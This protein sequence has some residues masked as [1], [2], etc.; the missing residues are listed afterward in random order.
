MGPRPC[1]VKVESHQGEEAEYFCHND[2][3]HRSVQF[4]AEETKKTGNHTRAGTQSVLIQ[5]LKVRTP[6]IAGEIKSLN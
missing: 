4:L 3:K 1:T 5:K 2:S 6:N